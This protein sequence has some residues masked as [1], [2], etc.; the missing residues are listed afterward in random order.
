LGSEVTKNPLK[1][2]SAKFLENLGEYGVRYEK[3]FESTLRTEAL[4]VEKM[5]IEQYEALHGV[6][7]AG[8]KVRF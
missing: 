2:Y 8:N 1:R 7:P 4:T 3:I 5:M 6:L